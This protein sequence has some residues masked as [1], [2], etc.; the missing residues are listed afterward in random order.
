MSLAVV[1]CTIS[2]ILL[3]T[4][5]ILCVAAPLD[6]N[7]FATGQIAYIESV[8]ATADPGSTHEYPASMQIFGSFTCSS[9]NWGVVP[10]VKWERPDMSDMSDELD[11]YKPFPTIKLHLS[12]PL[13]KEAQ[14]LL[15]SG[16]DE[17]AD[18]IDD[19]KQG[20]DYFA[21]KTDDFFEKTVWV[22]S[23]ADIYGKYFMDCHVDMKRAIQG[24]TYIQGLVGSGH[25]QEDK[26]EEVR[27]LM[28]HVDSPQKCAEFRKIVD[29][30]E[31]NLSTD[32]NIE[33]LVGYVVLCGFVAGVLCIGVWESIKHYKQCKETRDDTGVLISQQITGPPPVYKTI[34]V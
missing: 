8:C 15:D 11:L 24:I 14:K 9:N 27:F 18:T 28:K 25:S 30:A 20:S 32:V 19:F 22:M 4:T 5:V 26:M 17:L 1:K 6:N 29:E 21:K 33:A 12:D 34:D 23:A 10:T 3:Y 7:G 13:G 2:A 16:R 31:S